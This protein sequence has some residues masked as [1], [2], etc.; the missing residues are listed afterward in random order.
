[1]LE[2]SASVHVGWIMIV[3][4]I[5]GDWFLSSETLYQKE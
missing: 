2:D 3:I 5:E 1:M 4:S